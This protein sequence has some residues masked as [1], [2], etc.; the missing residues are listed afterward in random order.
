MAVDSL[1]TRWTNHLRSEILCVSRPR[2][3]SNEPDRRTCLDAKITTAVELLHGRPTGMILSRQ[4][5]MMIE[6]RVSSDVVPQAE[7]V[8]RSD[9]RERVLIGKVDQLFRDRL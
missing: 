4:R 1:S 2:R 5:S 8:R 6:A 9:T 3:F 7:Y